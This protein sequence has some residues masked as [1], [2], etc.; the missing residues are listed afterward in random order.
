M[1][2]GIV[3][4]WIFTYQI[5]RGDLAVSLF[6]C[7]Y[8]YHLD[9]LRPLASF[10]DAELNALAFFEVAIA[11]SNDSGIV[12]KNIFF[13]VFR[14]DKTKAFEAAEPL[15]RTVHAILGR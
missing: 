5:E 8:A 2:P 13:A 10:L 7:A 3:G 6:G 11:V 15:N 12:N 14:L 9:S 4:N 1:S